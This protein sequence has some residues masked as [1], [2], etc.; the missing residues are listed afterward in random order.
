MRDNGAAW[1]SLG[2]ASQQITYAATPRPPASAAITHSTRMTTT[3]MWNASAMPVATPAIIRPRSCRTKRHGGAWGGG[4]VPRSG[5]VVVMGRSC[6]RYGAST[7]GGNPDR[8]PEA[9][10]CRRIRS[11]RRGAKI[12]V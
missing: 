12:L 5:G 7:I 11:R 9:C 6:T 8:V 2:N 4:V 1:R 3:S 10:G